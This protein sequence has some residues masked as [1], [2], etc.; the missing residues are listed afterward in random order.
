VTP[1]GDI[2]VNGVRDFPQSHYEYTGVVFAVKGGPQTSTTF[3]TKKEK[4]NIEK[5]RN[6][7][8]W[9]GEKGT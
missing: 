6:R 7:V 2:I 8:E 3:P 5:E 9:K 1:A 4:M